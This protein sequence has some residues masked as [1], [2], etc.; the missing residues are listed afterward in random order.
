MEHVAHA[1]QTATPATEKPMQELLDEVLEFTLQD[2]QLNTEEHGA[3]QILHG[4]LAYQQAFP[5]RVGKN[6]PFQPALQYALDGGEIHG[7]TFQPGEV[8]DAATGRRG[9]RALVEPGTKQGQ[10]HADQWLAILSQCNLPIDQPLKIGSDLFTLRDLVDQVCRD[11]PYN[12][13]SEWSWTLIGLTQYLPTNHEWTAADGQTWSIARLVGA[14]AEQDINGS[15]CGGTHRLIGLAMA[16]QRHRAQGREVAGAWQNAADRIN[17]AIQIALTT[18]NPDGSFSTEYFRRP[19]SSPD[20]AVV[21]GST[22]HILEFLTLAMTD[23]QLRHPQVDLAARHLCQLFE[24]TRDLPLECGAL[25]HAAHGLVLYRERLF[26]TRKYEFR[27][28][29]EITAQSARRL[30]QAPPIRP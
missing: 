8:L 5:V 25:Y 18:Q 27:G 9:L 4:V 14:E 3:W 16:L 11:V 22:G 30:Q 12:V 15:A 29:P 1:D 2:R 28:S 23:D 7:W 21:L 17:Q 10:G 24:T 26:G 20:M 13:E 19:G 6:G